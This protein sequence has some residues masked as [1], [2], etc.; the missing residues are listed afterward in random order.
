MERKIK[1]TDLPRDELLERARE[2]IAMFDAQGVSAYV[3]FKFTCEQ[4]G[5]RCTLSDANTL[6]AFGEC[7][8]CGHTTEI[9]AGG[10]ALTAN[11]RQ[12]HEDT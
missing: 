5:F 6:H 1:P 3:N 4:C 8:K 11:L 10:F 7:C 2:A 12:K 9:V